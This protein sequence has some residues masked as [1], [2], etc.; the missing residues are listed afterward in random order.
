MALY[1]IQC[2]NRETLQ[3]T[4]KIAVVEVARRRKGLA[5]AEQTNKQPAAAEVAVFLSQNTGAER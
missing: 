1:G 3:P 5:D 2:S 4:D